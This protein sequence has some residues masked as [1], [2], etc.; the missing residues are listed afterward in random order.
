VGLGRGQ[1]DPQNLSDAHVS[2]TATFRIS[3]LIV[4]SMLLILHHE[5]MVTAL[6][7]FARTLLSG[8]ARI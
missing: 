8:W 1:F 3:T 7:A 6:V 2:D 4:R 5:T